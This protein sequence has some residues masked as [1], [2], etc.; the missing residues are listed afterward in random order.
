MKSPNFFMQL[1]LKGTGI[2]PSPSCRMRKSERSL[3]RQ[4]RQPHFGTPSKQARMGNSENPTISFNLE[5]FSLP[6][7]NLEHLVAPFTNEEIDQIIKQMPMDKARGPDGFN[8]QFLKK[9]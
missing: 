1:L 8:A 6:S 5:D 3:L 4:R 2:T 7:L 9:C